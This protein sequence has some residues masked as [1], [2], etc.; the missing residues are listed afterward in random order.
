[1]EEFDPAVFGISSAEAVLMDPQQR[2]LLDAL[3]QARAD[4]LAAAP[5]AW[6]VPGRPCLLA[7]GS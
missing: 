6:A 2:L 1:M 3:L 7:P 4:A 5:G